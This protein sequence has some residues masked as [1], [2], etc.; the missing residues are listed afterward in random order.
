[1]PCGRDK[2]LRPINR[3]ESQPRIVFPRSQKQLT[4]SLTVSDENAMYVF[5]S[6]QF[7]GTTVLAV[8][9]K[10]AACN[11]APCSDHPKCQENKREH[12]QKRCNTFLVVRQSP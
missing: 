8:L 11:R 1:M 5:L 12:G 10:N 3:L 6:H 2:Y 7:D 4:T 9:D